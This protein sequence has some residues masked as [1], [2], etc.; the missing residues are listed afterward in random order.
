MRGGRRSREGSSIFR[1]R[2]RSCAARCGRWPPGR[3]WRGRSSAI[4]RSAAW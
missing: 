4:W 2:R 3:S 1:G